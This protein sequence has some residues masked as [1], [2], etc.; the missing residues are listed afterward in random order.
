MYT[1]VTE[2]PIRIKSLVH[3]IYHAETKLLNATNYI[4]IKPE[5]FIS[6][7]ISIQKNQMN[8][9]SLVCNSSIINNPILAHF[10]NYVK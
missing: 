1:R 4:L 5:N 2:I 6:M 3:I 10:N 9:Q 8:Y 7:F